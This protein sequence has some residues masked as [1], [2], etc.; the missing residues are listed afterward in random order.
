M[1]DK[2]ARKLLFWITQAS[3]AVIL[4]LFWN[5]AWSVNEGGGVRST[6]SYVDNTTGSYHVVGEVL[7]GFGYTALVKV[8]ATFYDA[9]NKVV[10]TSVTFTNPEYVASGSTAPFELI[11]MDASVPM[12]QIVNYHIQALG[13]KVD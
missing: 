6:T 12:D 8:V 10:G 2:T 4:T 3:T 7:N 5:I 1:K 9:N 13:A 11:L